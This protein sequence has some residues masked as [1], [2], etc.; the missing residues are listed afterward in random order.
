[1]LNEPHTLVTLVIAILV[2]YRIAFLLT[3][4]DGPLDILF[5]IREKLGAYRRSETNGSPNPTS[6]G[7]WA[8]CPYCMGL[9]TAVIVAF[10]LFGIDLKALWLGLAIAGGQTFL[11]SQMGKS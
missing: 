4:E 2:N 3:M 8:S 5:I 11:Q 7:R 6:I 10:L 9:W 1:M